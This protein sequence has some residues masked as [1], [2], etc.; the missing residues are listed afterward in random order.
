MVGAGALACAWLG[1]IVTV[2]FF[3]KPFKFM[4]L[5]I[6]LGTAAIYIII[7]IFLPSSANNTATWIYN[8][9][10]LACGILV[11]VLQNKV[12]AETFRGFQNKRA[13]ED[14]Q[15]LLDPTSDSHAATTGSTFNVPPSQPAKAQST[16]PFESV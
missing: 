13:T 1:Y 3:E 10:G 4:S 7:L 11:S 5:A 9:V 16:N 6:G 15:P 8:F 12:F 14:Q 2:P